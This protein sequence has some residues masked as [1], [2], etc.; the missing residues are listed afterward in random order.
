MRVFLILLLLCTFSQATPVRVL[1]VDGFSNH[2]WQRNTAY[3]KQILSDKELFQVSTSTAGAPTWEP[4]FSAHDVVI[5]TCNDLG[6]KGSWPNSAQQQ[7]ETY[8]KNGGKMLVYHAGNNTFKD[9]DAYNEMIGLGWRDKNF[10]HAVEIID[11]KTILIPKGKGEHTGHGPRFDAQVTRLADH[12]LHRGLPRRWRAAELEV[13]RFAR[14]P[15]K[16]LTVLS[17]AEDPKT[18][19]SFPV[20]WTVKYGKG[21]VH[22]STYGHLWHNQKESPPGMRCLA[23]HTLLKRSLLWLS[24]KPIPKLSPNEFPGTEKPLL[25]PRILPFQKSRF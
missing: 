6:N 2:D 16:K 22:G 1:I 7:L 9:W 24:G 14:G 15:A 23:F 18:R 13:Y 5:Q 10:G 11:G 20:S 17:Y 21:T 25:S 19:K 4:D 12:P 8:L 3:L